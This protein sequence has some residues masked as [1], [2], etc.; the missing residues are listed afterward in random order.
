MRRISFK[1]FALNLFLFSVL[2]VP[3]SSYA[4]HG[5]EAE[6]FD[7]SGMIMHHVSD[8]HQWHFFNIG[9]H[10]VALH[11][12]VILYSADR[13]LEVFSSKHFY[14]ESEHPHHE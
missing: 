3:Q 4:S 2:L 6:K 10:P 7:I 1:V 12:P 8:A 11:L 9:D 5:E 14:G 13:G